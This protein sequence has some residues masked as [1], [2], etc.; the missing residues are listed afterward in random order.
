MASTYTPIATTTLGSAASSVTF[1]SISGTYTDLVLVCNFGAD[2]ASRLAYVRFNNDSAT[3][4]SNTYV[5]GT[6]SAAS[7]ARN[8]NMTLIYLDG[9]SYLQTTL[10][11]NAIMNIQNY[12]NTTTYKTAIHR[13]NDAAGEALASADLWRSTSAITRV[14]VLISAG[15][16]LAG[17]TFTLYGI[18]AA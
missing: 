1:N 7:S 14:D 12:S 17:S 4:Y 3:N 15:N 18:K 8:G 11:G 10:T 5:A 2:S 6:G 13:Y 9:T 16:F